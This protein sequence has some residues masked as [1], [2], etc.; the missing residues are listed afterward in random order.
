M[1]L[2]IESVEHE[3][4]LLFVALEKN[5]AGTYSLFYKKDFYEEVSI[6][7]DHLPAYFLKL[8]GSDV[9]SIFDLYFQD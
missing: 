8:Y 4:Q 9:L 3:R 2:K 7:A 6:V 1:A 5:Q